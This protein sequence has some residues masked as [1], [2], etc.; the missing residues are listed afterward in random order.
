M[1]S[2]KAVNGIS[3]PSTAHTGIERIDVLV[4]PCPAPD[5]L[6]KVQ[7][8]LDAQAPHA[9]PQEHDRRIAIRRRDTRYYGTHG[10]FGQ[11]NY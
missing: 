6:R 2:P 1:D 5:L 11:I 4:N 10:S 7:E 9:V 8:V 3:H